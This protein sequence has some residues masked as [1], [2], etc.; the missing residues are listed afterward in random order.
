M[1][2]ALLALV[3]CVA[4]MTAAAAEPIT[5]TVTGPAGGPHENAICTGPASLLGDVAPGAYEG[6]TRD[7]VAVPVQVDDLDGDGVADEIVAVVNLPADG[8]TSL[9]VDPAL[10]WDGE[11]FADARTSWRY[12][13]YPVLDTD[14]MGFGLYGVDADVHFLRGMQ[15]DL[16][17]KRPEAWRLSLDELESVDYHSDNPVAVD[18][19]L[20][21]D[22][23]AL[24][25]PMIG[26]SRPVTGENAT[27]IA[28]VLY[29]GPV[30]AGLEVT[31]SD[32]GTGDRSYAMVAEYVVYAHHAF[33]DARF[34]VA[35]APGADTPFS[36]GVRRIPHPDEFLARAEE[37]ILGIIG[38]QPGIIGKTGL[39]LIFDPAQFLRW[40]V[41]EGRDDGYLVRLQSEDGTY[42]A[43]LVGVWDQGGMVTSETFAQHLRDLAGRFAAPATIS[44]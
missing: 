14:A 30:R 16:Y 42:R 8:E 18:V 3:C 33:I 37:G 19:L 35:P 44:R 27:G 40:D 9:W 5:L 22:S 21:A 34:R 1:I 12:D 7:G 4:V 28:R 24:G 38:Q 26:A 39:A 15:W 43:W 6:A 25:G 41:A 10:P 36:L 17:G 32:W 2:R 20:V 31:V 11:D 13:N 23:V 29:D